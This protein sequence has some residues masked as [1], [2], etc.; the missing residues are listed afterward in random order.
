MEILVGLIGLAGATVAVIGW[1]YGS[2]FVCVFLTLPVAAVFVIA[3]SNN[4]LATPDWGAGCLLAL[5]IIWTPRLVW[6]TRR[7]SP[8]LPSV[9]PPPSVAPTPDPVDNSARLAAARAVAIWR[10]AVTTRT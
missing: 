10:R 8:P 5:I 3:A 7:D 4:G 9:A 6:L 1:F 2:L